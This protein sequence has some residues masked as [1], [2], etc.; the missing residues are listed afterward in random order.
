MRSFA[1]EHIR[2]GSSE[3][4]W[5]ERGDITYKKCSIAQFRSSVKLHVA[6]YG[7]GISAVVEEIT[8]HSGVAVEYNVV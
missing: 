8:A 4:I 5:R 2:R 3:D 6:R 1:A 7:A